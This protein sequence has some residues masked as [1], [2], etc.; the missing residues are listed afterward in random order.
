[1]AIDQNVYNAIE[2]TI[3]PVLPYLRE[4]H[5]R[6][7]MGSAANA[8][9]F[10]GVAAVNEMTGAAR[11]TITKGAEEV[12]K[13]IGTSEKKNKPIRAA[14]A[15]R[16]R[17]R[18]KVD[19]Y[20]EV[21][22]EI[23]DNDIYGNPEKVISYTTWS[24]R[25]I[26]DEMGRRGIQTNKNAVSEAL[27]EL[28][29]SRQKNQKMDQVGEPHPDRDAQFRYI[30]E[31]ASAFLKEGMPVISV[32]T[33]KKENIGNFK[34][35]GSE[36]RPKGEPRQ[37]LDHDFPIP[38]LGKVNP[39]GIYDVDKNTAFINLGIS[40]DTPLFAANSILRWWQNIG[41]ATYPKATKILITPDSGGSNGY[42]PRMWKYQLQE[43]AN[44]T[45]LEIHVC[46]YPTGASKW[47]KIE[48]RAFCYI[49]KNWQGKPLID[50]ETVVNLISTT[51]TTGGLSVKC[52][53]DKRHYDLGEK[54]SDEDFGKINIEHCGPN[55]SWNY[56]IRP[57]NI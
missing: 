48:H 15:G 18:D 22:Q 14:G 24:L 53:V 1:M 49:S 50:I 16:K 43:I 35:E 10:G 7:L 39:Y 3:T 57:N 11:N 41:C 40:A 55:E 8:M 25:D 26:A 13:T 45:G 37:V 36:Y 12:K 51:T 29:Y 19:G 23:I 28:G 20:L 38:E 30:N 4:D 2:A 52:V 42:R 44:I 32:D 34:N 6:L 5:Q 21:L 46:H 9:G 56:I 27:E 31:Q 33:K 17:T 54:V 47:N